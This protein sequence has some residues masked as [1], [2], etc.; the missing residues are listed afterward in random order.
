MICVKSVYTGVI[1]K[2]Y[3]MPKFGGWVRVSE[4]EWNE[5]VSRRGF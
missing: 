1:Y 5:Q 3:E 2:V 4:E